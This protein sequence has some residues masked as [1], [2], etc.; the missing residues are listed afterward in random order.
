MFGKIFGSIKRAFTPKHGLRA[1][2]KKYA[3]QVAGGLALV[4][5]GMAL[6]KTMDA[7]E[8]GQE[9]YIE[10]GS[11]PSNVLDKSWNLLKIEDIEN[12][13]S[14]QGFPGSV[15]LSTWVLCG[16][17]FLAAIYPS[18]LL[19]KSAKRCIISSCIFGGGKCCYKTKTKEIE[20]STSS[21]RAKDMDVERMQNTELHENVYKPVWTIPMPT[22]PTPPVDE[23][24]THQ[25]PLYP[26]IDLDDSMSVGE[27]NYNDIRTARMAEML[28]TLK[29]KY[30][31]PVSE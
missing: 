5:G 7:I 14:T 24:H 25:Q 2:R 15:S 18:W 8:G 3:P 13:R 22:L 30:E 6:D 21:W 19:F 11:D 23:E 31:Q 10:Y 16:L 27:N 12:G 1:T 29:Q 26:P 9:G 4:G 20:A 28:E 17:V